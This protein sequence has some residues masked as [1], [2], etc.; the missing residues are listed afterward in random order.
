M[1][2]WPCGLMGYG[3]VGA[4]AILWVIGGRYPCCIM[5]YR[6]ALYPHRINYRGPGCLQR[7]REDYLKRHLRG[8]GDYLVDKYWVNGR[9]AA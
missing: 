3:R 8:D 7:N 1:H 6:G 5:V 4:H 2:S 9:R